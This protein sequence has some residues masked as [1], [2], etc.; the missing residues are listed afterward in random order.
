[1]TTPDPA[2]PQQPAPPPS[3]Y[4]QQPAVPP[5]YQ[6]P[7]PPQ[8]VSPA[9]SP[10]P[11]YPQQAYPAPAYDPSQPGY[12]QPGYQQPVYGPPGY[13][14]PGFP[15][16]APPRKSRS[17][18]WIVIA[19]AAVVLVGCGVGYFKVIKPMIDESNAHLGTPQTVAGLQL[20][21]DPSLVNVANTMKTELR[22]EVKEATSS[23]GAFYTDPSGDRSKLVMVVGV[24]GR[25]ANPSGELDDAFGGLAEGGFSASEP[26]KVDAGPLGGEARCASAIASGQPLIVCAWADHGSVAMILFFNRDAAES[27]QLFLQ[28]RSAI[29]TR[30]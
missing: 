27:E 12:Q 17:W 7:T 8:P 14:Q 22:N 20:S 15:P 16:A 5:T 9:V 26:H 6:Q 4:P 11:V 18:I 13:V 28:M 21:T 10:P 23:I 29:E 30:D 19:I 1:M 25:V 24:T 3:A 2:D